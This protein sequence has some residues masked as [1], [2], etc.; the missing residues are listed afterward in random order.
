M[1]EPAADTYDAALAL[2][3]AGRMAD[4][5]GVLQA[6]LQANSDDAAAWGLLT[7]VRQRLGQ[8]EAALACANEVV[9]LTPEDAA[10]HLTRGNLLAAVGQVPRALA[11]FDEAARLA[12]DL[13]VAHNN[14]AG[15]LNRLERSD[16][17]LA[18][19][20]RALAL[21]PRLSHAWR[22]RA[23]ALFSR[24]DG[25]SAVATY[26]RALAAASPPERYD[27]LCDLGLSLNAVGDHAEALQALDEAVSLQPAAP[28]A[29][30][31]RSETRLTLGDLP[32]GWDDYATRW[33]VGEFVR[34][35]REMTPELRR[36]LV[37]APQADDL[38]GRRI[39]V[40]RE[41]GVGDEIMF[42]GVLP[43][44]AAIAAQVTCIVNPRLLQL[45]SR[46]LPQITFVPSGSGQRLD[47]ADFDRV[48]ALGSLPFMF[49]RAPRDFPG[50]GYLSPDPALV[51]G[52][53]RRL[54]VTGPGLRVGLSWRGGIKRTRAAARSL[55]LAALAP[56]LSREDCVFVSL[57]YG[58]VAAEIAEVNAGRARPIIAFP[59]DE[60]HDFEDLAGLTG[61]MDAVVTVQ[62]ALA[63]LV[64]AMGQDGLV[65]IPRWPEW[66]YGLGG[67]RMAWYAS[68]RLVRQVDAGD[69]SPV[70]ADV[71]RRLD[72]MTANEMGT[73]NETGTPNEKTPRGGGAS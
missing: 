40:V 20:D 2:A 14:R 39:L 29:R 25:E 66:R 43:D 41:Q 69:W 73:S 17:A 34:T 64:G 45:F 12:P 15:M 54:A 28:M 65:M 9:R 49:R 24:G 67:E 6:V 16:E 31:R 62:T 3:R 59:A 46:S 32:G 1:T 47:P 27:A 36:R 68:L 5:A 18:A 55:D 19:A 38:R 13:A 35:N 42:A 52:W 8:P 57:Q 37:V 60:T 33:D 21:D 48:V 63:H 44:L 71:A 26:R 23:F 7:A 56:L 30:F 58:D 50:R 51:E 72:A 70:L 4:A 22:H 10:A 61:A 53:R 11:S